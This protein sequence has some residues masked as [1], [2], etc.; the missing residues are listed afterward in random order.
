MTETVVFTPHLFIGHTRWYVGSELCSQGAN[1]RPLQWTCRVLPLITKEVPYILFFF[2]FKVKDVFVVCGNSLGKILR[3]FKII[4]LC[5]NEEKQ[6][7]LNSEFCFFFFCGESLTINFQ[8]NA[9]N[10]VENNSILLF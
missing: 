7:L 4:N 1:P 6:Y 8:T 2:F 3:N 9:F 5:D 10:I